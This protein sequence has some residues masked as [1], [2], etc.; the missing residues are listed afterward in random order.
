MDRIQT[1]KPQNMNLPKLNL[2]PSFV[3]SLL[4]VRLSVATINKIASVLFI[5]M[6]QFAVDCTAQVEYINTDRP[7]QSDGV[8]TV[9]KNKFQL[10]NG[11]IVAKETFLNELMVRYGITHSTE[12]R[13]IADAGKVRGK[14]GMEPLTFSLKQRILNQKRI[15]PAITFVGYVSF[16]RL[17]SKE[18]Q[19][20]KIPF[21][22]KLAFENELSDKFSLGYNVGTS[23]SFKDLDLT[24]GLSY[25]PIE[26]ISAFVEYF[27]TLSKIETEHNIDVGILYVI[28]PNLQF[29]LA[30]GR[31]LFDSADRF[32]T[33]IGVSYLFLRY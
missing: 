26:K 32:F 33:T 22:L 5:L 31:S 15:F 19:G 17:A 30:G 11:I 28:K 25:T 4:S 13:M 29:D 27:S 8:Y 6:I 16:E 20:N 1:G 24:M 9:P 2:H 3:R 23:N 7:D 18:F 12:V 14:R 10:E 21:E